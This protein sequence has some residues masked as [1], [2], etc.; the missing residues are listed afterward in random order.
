MNSVR[1]TVLVENTAGQRC[2]LAEHGLSFLIESDA[3]RILFDTGQGLALRHNTDQLAADLKTVEAVVL[4]HGHY[5]HTGG[6]PVALTAM[7]RPRVYAC[8]EAFLPKYTRHADGTVHEIGMPSAVRKAVFDQSER[9][10]VRGVLEIGERMFL[11]GPIPRTNRFEDTGG[12]FFKD[13]DCKVPDELPDDQAIF[14]TTRKGTVVIAGCAHAGI[15]NTLRYIRDLTE[16]QP[17]R[18]VIGG[19]HLL[20]ASAGRMRRTVA[21]LREMDIASIHPCHCTGFEAVARLWNEFPNSCRPC[22][23]GTVMRFEE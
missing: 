15:I 21:G 14:I 8:R 16:G 7:S 13:A 11:T 18:A 4:S 23:A 2:L 5:D 1:I 3:Q 6:L 12:A 9:T 10:D 22:P 20:H 17:V 19:L